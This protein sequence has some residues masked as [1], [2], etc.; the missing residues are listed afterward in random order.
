[1]NQ[2]I[3]ATVVLIA[4][5]PESSRD[6]M[7]PQMDK[8]GATVATRPLI[9]LRLLQI[10]RELTTVYRTL[11]GNIPLR[12]SDFRALESRGASPDELPQYCCVH[13]LGRTGDLAQQ[14]PRIFAGASGRQHEQH[15]VARMR[16]H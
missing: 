7:N 14:A 8:A 12:H 16:A 15:R 5:P 9:P 2:I 10:P 11:D 3:C 1:M 13:R 6:Q 4:T